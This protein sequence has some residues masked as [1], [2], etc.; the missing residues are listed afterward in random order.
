[1]NPTILFETSWE[2]CN[3]VGG[4]YTVLSTKAK[5]IIGTAAVEIVENSEEKAHGLSVLMSHYSDNFWGEF[6]KEML[7]SVSVI[8]IIAD[9][10]SCKEH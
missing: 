4:I 1:M 9:K 10:W 8:K 6:Q 7:D 3:K 2:V 5:V